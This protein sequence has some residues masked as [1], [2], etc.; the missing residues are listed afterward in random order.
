MLKRIGLMGLCISASLA[1]GALQAEEA[2]D[3]AVERAEA[4]VKTRESLMYLVRWNVVPMAGMV[5]EVV[6]YDAGQFELNAQRLAQ[7][8]AMV[9][10]A[11]RADVRGVDIPTESRPEIWDDY[12]KFSAL[13]AELAESS[14]ELARVSAAGDF[15]ASKEA[16]LAVGDDCKACHD[17]FR[18]DD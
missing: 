6:P 18:L 13:A 3:P 11:F 5:K 4:A 10:D 8:A 16:F 7:L 15:A 1:V 9:E 14:S 2:K 17:K 12:A